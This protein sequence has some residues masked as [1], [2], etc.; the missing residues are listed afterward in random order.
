M[1][2]KDKT[3]DA[4]NSDRFPSLHNSSSVSFLSLLLIGVMTTLSVGKII[5]RGEFLKLT[6]CVTLEKLSNF[7]IDFQVAGWLNVY[8]LKSSVI[9][10]TSFIL[11]FILALSGITIRF[12]ST[13]PL[14]TE[15]PHT[16]WFLEQE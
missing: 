10:C 8:C 4:G 12:S 3:I 11:M 15:N 2:Q 5:F 16:S 13:F 14:N 7:P 6:N 1:V 9:K